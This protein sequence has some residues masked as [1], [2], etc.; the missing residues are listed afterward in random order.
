MKRLLAGCLIASAVFGQ[1]E[2]LREESELTIE[3]ELPEA[4]RRSDVPVFNSTKDCEAAKGTYH[5]KLWLPRGYLASGQRR[6]PCMFIADPGGNASFGEMGAWLQSHGYVVVMLVESKNG[7]WPPIIGNFLAAHDDVVKRVRIQEGLKFA[8]GMSGGARA[9]AVFVQLRPGFSGLVLQ[10]AGLAYGDNNQY[11]ASGL[12][13]IPGLLVAMTMGDSD[14]NHGEL[15]RTKAALGSSGFL[16]VEFKGGHIWA[17][18]DM[19]A[20]AMDWIERRLFEEGPP[21]PALKA[22]YAQR[23]QTQLDQ[24]ATVTAPWPRYKQADALLAYARNR[25]LMF[26]PAIAPALSKVQLEHT[27]LRTD[28]A[29]TREILAADALRR[30]EETREKMPATMF[31]TS[32]RNLAKQYPGTEAAAKAQQLADVK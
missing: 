25:N 30:L 32:C 18:P 23:A 29:I 15:T 22:V 28:P 6:W 5:Y 20:R 31:A 27:R 17:P 14:S 4:P 26:D 19:F 8:T 12:K 21:N 7:P 24:L 2:P 9:C 13:R 10:G 1:S 16:A 3:C 11:H